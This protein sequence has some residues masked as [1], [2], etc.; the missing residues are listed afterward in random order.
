MINLNIPNLDHKDENKLL[1]A[2]KSGWIS[3]AGP[4]I[5]KFETEFAEFVGSKYAIACS[6]GTA[7]LH[8]SLSSLR[9]GNNSDVITPA[10]SFIATANSIKYL[11]ASTVFVDVE[12]DTL[13]IDFQKG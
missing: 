9:I 10:L 8:V 12:E 7:A 1:E 4:D 13:A 6:S 11:G 5:K 3:S 2:I